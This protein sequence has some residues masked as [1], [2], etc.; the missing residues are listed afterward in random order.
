VAVT[1]RPPSPEEFR[2][3]ADF[4]FAL[5]RF[6]ADADADVRAEGLTP[7]RY[8]LMLAIKASA[9]GSPATITQIADQLRSAQ[10]SVTELVDRAVAAGLLERGGA[11]D[12]RVVTVAL[13][14]HGEEIFARAFAAVRDDRE[15]LFEHL[16]AS[17]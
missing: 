16:K 4:R 6:I 14:E 2:R 11:S 9:S 15:R 7:H 3:A 13:T 17:E 10:S 1:A 8:L 5:R 12:G